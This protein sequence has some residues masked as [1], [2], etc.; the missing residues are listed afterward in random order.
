MRFGESPLPTVVTIVTNC[1]AASYHPVTNNHPADFCYFL[2][3]LLL[4]EI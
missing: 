2:K 3:V 4:A 1:Y